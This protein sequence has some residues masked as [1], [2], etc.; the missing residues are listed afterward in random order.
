MYGGMDG[1]MDGWIDWFILDGWIGWVGGF[2]VGVGVCFNIYIT[3]SRNQTAF[4]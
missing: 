3:K 4:K 1:W 2:W